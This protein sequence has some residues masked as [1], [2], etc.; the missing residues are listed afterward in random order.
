MSWCWAMRNAEVYSVCGSCSR[1]P[2]ASLLSTH[3]PMAPVRKRVPDCDGEHLVDKLCDYVL[4][5]GHSAAF[6]LGSYGDVAVAQAIRGAAL[7]WT[8][9]CDR[10]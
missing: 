1:I 2:L 7:A 8:L 4:H 9:V 5:V 6:E 10:A 3:R